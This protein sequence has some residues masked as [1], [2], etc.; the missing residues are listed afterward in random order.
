MFSI[1][2]THLFIY[3]IYLFVTIDVASQIFM[4]HVILSLWQK[5]FFHLW[6]KSEDVEGK[7]TV[8][9]SANSIRSSLDSQ[10]LTFWRWHSCCSCR[11][12]ISA[13]S[14]PVNPNLQPSLLMESLSRLLLS[15]SSTFPHMIPPHALVFVPPHNQLFQDLGRIGSFYDK[16]I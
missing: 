9:S 13:W 14:V 16:Q 15:T 7:W 8:I 12:A 2:L 3:S 6:W 1:Y 11:R 4:L 10:S 5:C